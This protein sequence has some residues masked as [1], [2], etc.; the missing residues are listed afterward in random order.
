MQHVININHIFIIYYIHLCFLIWAT[1]LH[2]API[3]QGLHSSFFLHFQ[4]E[5]G[6]RVYFLLV[7]RLV[8][9]LIYHAASGYYMCLAEWGKTHVI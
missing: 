4:K 2:R 8:I 5:V 9:V 7:I 1:L 6:K 3:S